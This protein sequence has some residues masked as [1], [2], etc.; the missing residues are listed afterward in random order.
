MIYIFDHINISIINTIQKV[1][2]ER[3]CAPIFTKQS[4]ERFSTP[5]NKMSS[6]KEKNH[7]IH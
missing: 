3:V 1:N 5:W 2:W 7:K 6:D 4:I